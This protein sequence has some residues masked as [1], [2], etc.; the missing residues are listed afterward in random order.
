MEDAAQ[1][2]SLDH[3]LRLR[4][5]GNAAIIVANHVHHARFLDRFEHRLGFLHGHGERLFA[6]DMLAGPGGGDGDLRMRVVRRVDVENIDLGIGHDFAPIGHRVFPAE[7]FRRGPDALLVASANRVQLRHRRDGEKFINLPPRV[8]MGLA[9]E[10]VTD[11]SDIERLHRIL[12][13]RARLRVINL[14]AILGPVGLMGPR[15]RIG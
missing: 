3:L 6:E 4:D 8:R 1:V 2:A 9:H 13:F 14:I 12:T 15:G 10:L 7:L 5:G 11:H